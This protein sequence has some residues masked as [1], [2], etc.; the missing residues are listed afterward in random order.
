[1]ASDLGGGPIWKW[2]M[3]QV[4]SANHVSER[5][6]TNNKISISILECEYPFLFFNLLE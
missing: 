6:K 2:G 3:K 4:N 1:M 5:L